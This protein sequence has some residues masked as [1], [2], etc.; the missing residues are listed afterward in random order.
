MS[1]II[2]T[3]YNRFVVQFV[4]PKRGIYETYFSIRSAPPLNTHFNILCL[5]LIPGHFL[6]VFLKEG[7]PLPLACGEWKN[8]K[9]GEVEQWEFPFMDRQVLFKDFMSKEPKPLKKPTNELNPIYYD[10]PT[11]DKPKQEFEVM[12]EDED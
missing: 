11:P 6:H 7:Y 2:A 5:G 3:C 12:E 1:H 4:F 9:I 10:T 8:Q